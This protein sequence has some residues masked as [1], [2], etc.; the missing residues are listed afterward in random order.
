MLKR[1]TPSVANVNAP[2]CECC[3]WQD[4]LAKLER[5]KRE[6]LSIFLGNRQAQRR[7]ARRLAFINDRIDELRRM[8]ALPR[9]FDDE[10]ILK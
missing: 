7:A 10:D 2:R 6:I 9:F 4:E 8:I 1:N 5:E 3:Q